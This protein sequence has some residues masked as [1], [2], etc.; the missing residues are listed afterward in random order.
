MGPM[1]LPTLAAC[2]L[3]ARTQEAPPPAAD[4]RRLAEK[5]LPSVVVL[6]VGARDG[7]A[8]GVGTGFVVSPDGLVATNLHVI[9]EG[10]PITVT[11]ADGTS[12]EVEAVHATERAVDLAVLKI[13]AEKLPALPLAPG[14]PPAKGE[15]VVAIG[16]PQGLR[17]SVVSGVV[18]ARREVG[19]MPM[20]Q[21]ALPVEPGNS[22]G[23][24]LDREG[25]VVGILT[26]K[27]AMTEN[28]GFA[29]EIAALRPLLER[30]NPV[31]MSSWLTIG[32]L[33]EREWKVAEGGRWRQRAG[34]IRVEGPGAGFGGRSLCVSRA[35][36]P[37]PPYEVAVDVRLEHD[38]GA[39]GLLFASDGGDGHYGFYP[40]SGSLRL[41]AFNGPDVFSWDILRTLPSPHYRPG[42][43]NSLRV[44]VEEK[45]VSC[46]V[47]GKLV[48]ESEDDRYRRGPAGLA[49]FRHTAAEFRGFRVGRSLE[50]AAP[51]PASA[52]RI[53]GALEALP[54]E[55]EIPAE[56]LARLAAEPPG[57]SLREQ[58]AALERRAARIRAL[59]RA[60]HEKR[61]QDRLAAA[62]A[63][64]DEKVDLLHA[65][66]LLALLDNPEVDV[67]AYR[68]DFERM[69]R[70]AAA[71]VPREGAPDARLR[72]LNR[73]FFEQ[74]RFHGSR[75]D[76]YNR[77]NSYLNEV[78]DDREGL[79]ISLSVLYME[80]ARRIGMKVVGV[81]LPGHFVV[82]Y[83]PGEGEGRLVDV[84]ERGREMTLD[85][86]KERVRAS[87]GGALE[88]DELEA[89][90]REALKPAPKRAIVARMIRNLLGSAPDD[91]ARL[92]T[93]SAFLVVEPD[94]PA[95]RARRMQLAAEGGRPRQ[96]LADIDWFLEKRPPGLD[97]ERV[98]ELR[99]R[100]EE[101]VGSSP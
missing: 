81:P 9:G 70:D 78:M 4:A 18:S 12:A 15:P 23:P 89:R 2:L 48:I 20:I 95:M 44:R 38:D 77:S 34:R 71:A 80:L 54:A 35:E 79:P 42:E 7:G 87:S 32:R 72:A 6:T 66:L 30:P 31:P 62:L 76:Y 65:A 19:G 46:F 41:T 85:E 51:D 101:R 45:K 29:V 64:D 47:N 52:R 16:N 60:V 3:L 83:E 61:V 55:G 57:P 94:D 5:A 40:T 84:F 49:K 25:R 26:L 93:A 99:R 27:S 28:L 14:E 92:R 73:F 22:G 56:L 43:W 82:R 50:A 88:A 53:A 1:V 10:R 97:L 11:F 75:S 17:H 100:L 90:T 69:A 13:K 96:A 74:L 68:R 39:A 36:V 59:E 8:E 98:A 58:A 86:A 63:G 37:E 33:D 91:E 67:E 21:L 24:V